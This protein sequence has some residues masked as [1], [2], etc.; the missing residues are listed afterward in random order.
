MSNLDTLILAIGCFYVS[1][2]TTRV[3][4]LIYRSFC[5]TKCTT[6][7]YGKKTWAVVAGI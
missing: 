2:W 7:R 4:A 3:L 5:G 1:I 6:E